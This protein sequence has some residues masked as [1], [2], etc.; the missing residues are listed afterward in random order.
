MQAAESATK[1]VKSATGKSLDT[2]LPLSST[3]LRDQHSIPRTYTDDASKQADKT[4]KQANE[5]FEEV[6]QSGNQ[7]AAEARGKARDVK[8]AAQK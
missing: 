7:A 8:D 6:K 2:L 1:D 4:A 3:P 5:T